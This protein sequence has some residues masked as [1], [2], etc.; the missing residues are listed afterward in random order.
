MAS[1]IAANVHRK[2][3]F[4]TR[5]NVRIRH[6]R[7]GFALVR[8]INTKA[9]TIIAA[10]KERERELELGNES[11]ADGN[12]AKTLGGNT[13]QTGQQT[14]QK[15]N[16]QLGLGGQIPTDFPAPQRKSI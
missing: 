10:P 7:P 1:R 8:N 9:A 11:Q 3:L 12:A 5:P 14:N 13:T 2:D 4:P 6:P 15:G 16:T